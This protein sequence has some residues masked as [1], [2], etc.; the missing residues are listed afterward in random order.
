M[1]YFNVDA[2]RQE[3]DKNAQQNMCTD[4]VFYFYFCFCYA[5]APEI[6]SLECVLIFWLDSVYIGA[7][8]HTYIRAKKAHQIY[9]RIMKKLF[10]DKIN[11]NI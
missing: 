4:G 8:V 6:S 2:N 11:T 1:E 5:S 3:N 9:V 10:F 7:N